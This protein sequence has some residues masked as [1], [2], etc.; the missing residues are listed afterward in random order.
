[1]S[2]TDSPSALAVKKS[3]KDQ[4]FVT[5]EYQDAIDELPINTAQSIATLL[6]I[7]KTPSVTE[8]QKVQTGRMKEE[9]IYILVKEYLKANTYQAIQ[10]LFVAI[11]PYF[12]EISKPRSAKIIRTIIDMVI[13]SNTVEYKDLIT[14]V[15]EAI[16]WSI[17]EKRVFVR[18]RL[19]A[20]LAQL[21]ALNLQYRDA[22]LTIR[23]LMKEIKKIRR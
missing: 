23:K 19:Q 1:M 16:Q 7:V 20:K 17:D 3:K 12:D 13:D 14:L 11:R 2:M 4:F 10:E 5:E 15:L 9:A 21:Y 18:Q 22:L 8:Q 6:N